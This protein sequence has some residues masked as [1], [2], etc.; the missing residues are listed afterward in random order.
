[1]SHCNFNKP[2][3][4][5]KRTLKLNKR[6]RS[7]EK[8]VESKTLK[9]LRE[10]QLFDWDYTLRCLSLDDPKDIAALIKDTLDRIDIPTV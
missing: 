5:E 9:A 6:L 1:M 10:I 4:A 8:F 2:T 7:I 3:K